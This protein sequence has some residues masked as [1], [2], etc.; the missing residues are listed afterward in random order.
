[1]ASIIKSNTYADFNGREI[2]TANNDGALTTQKI[3]YP[4]FQA[5]LS[6]SQTGKADNTYFKVAF[7]QEDYDTDGAFDTSN[8]RF[9]VPTG[10]AGKYF[11]HT[12]CALFRD[13]DAA[14]S[15]DVTY[16]SF[17]KNGSRVMER[18]NGFQSNPVKRFSAQATWTCDLVVGDYIEV[19]AAVNVTGGTAGVR[20]SSA[21][22]NSVFLGYRI[23]S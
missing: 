8:Y 21:Q 15:I 3:N 16:V 20:E 19:Y 5:V 2:L 10:K 22:E 1:M 11:F 17:Y 14:S 9:T 6:A 4:A 23:G 13:N 12:S 18:Q 7:D